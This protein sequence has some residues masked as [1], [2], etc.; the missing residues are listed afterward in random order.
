MNEASVEVGSG[1]VFRIVANNNSAV[2][3]YIK[4]VTLNG[5]PYDKPYIDFKDIAAEGKLVFEMNN[6]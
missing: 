5:K 3:K 6:M 4:S 1:K 2:N